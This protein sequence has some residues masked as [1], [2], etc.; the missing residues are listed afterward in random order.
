MRRRAGAAAVALLTLVTCVTGCNGSS[1]TKLTIFAASSLTTT[2]TR[3]EAKFEATHPNVDVVLSF[4]SST[5]LAQQITAGAPADVIATADQ[6]SVSLVVKAHQLAAP[7]SPFA[8][9]DL[10]IAVPSGNPGH[11]T[12]VQS[13]DSTGF[14][15]CQ[16]SAPCGAAGAQMLANAGVTAQPKSFE[17]D[18]A[19]VLAQ[20]ELKE[21]DAGIVYVTD[22]QSAAD[23]VDA[24]QIPAAV[25]VTNEYYIAPVMGSDVA[26]LATA[27]ISLVT[28]AAGSSVL[29]EAGFGAP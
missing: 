13:L 18:V 27:W 22:A 12:G 25:N 16:V 4:G 9:N 2:F 19:T 6:T 8:S 28:S 15:M 11:V 26:S 10:T 29:A 7:P 23:K 5:T 1:K 24:V 17:P 14:I 3:L 20:I 21:A